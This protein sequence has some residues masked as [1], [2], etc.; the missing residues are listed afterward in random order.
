MSSQLPLSHCTR[1]DRHYTGTTQ[2]ANTFFKGT[3]CSLNIPQGPDGTPLLLYVPMTELKEVASGLL[4]KKKGC[5]IPQGPES[6]LV[7]NT[8]PQQ[9]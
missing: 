5:N 7:L 4:E 6:A 8:G 9:G 2:E 1:K 3:V